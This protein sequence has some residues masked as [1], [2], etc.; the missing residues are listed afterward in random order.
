MGGPF[1]MPK[2]IRRRITKQGRIL[3]NN[4]VPRE[5]DTRAEIAPILERVAVLRDPAGISRFVHA[6]V[7]LHQ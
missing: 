4:S 2:L 5:S 6:D 7:C 3:L 1:C